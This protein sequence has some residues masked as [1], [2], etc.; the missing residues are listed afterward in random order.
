MYRRLSTANWPFAVKFAFPGLLAF[1]LV[2][3]LELSAT[4]TIN[5]LN[6]NLHDVVDYKFNAS[7]LLAS[8]VSKLRAAN[9]GLYHLQ[10]LQAAGLAPNVNEEAQTITASLDQVIVNLTK[11]KT[12]YAVAADMTKIDAALV[13][14]KNYKDAVGFVASMLDI[15]FKAT[16]NFLTPLDSAYNQ[17]I[18]D[19]SSIATQY[20]EDS[21]RQ[22][23]EAL[24][25]AEQQKINLYL[26]SFGA[27]LFTLLIV[28]WIALT[29]LRS[30]N[31]VAKATQDL[32]E[33]NVD[34][35][36]SALSRRDELNRIVQA[37]VFKGNLVNMRLFKAENITIA[38]MLDTLEQGLFSFGSDGV[39]LPIYSKACLNLIEGSPAGRPIAE[40]L[41]QDFSMRETITLL[42]DVLFCDSENLSSYDDILGLLPKTFV[43][44]QGLAI[45]L[46]YR[47]IRKTSGEL[48][49]ILVAATDHTDKVAAERIGQEREK[50]VL[51]MLR[52]IENRNL[53]VHFYL[54]ASAYCLSLEEMLSGQVTLEQIKRDV[55]TMK[56]NGS[57]FY[58]EGLVG[59]LHDLETELSDVAT[60]EEAGFVLRRVL[61]RM[62]NSLAEV[63]GDVEAVLGEGF[64]RQGVMR[65]VPLERLKR[66]VDKVQQESSTRELTMSV[67]GEP[68]RKQLSSLDMG[69]QELA[70]R[71]GKHVDP[72]VFTGDDFLI[73]SEH[74]K[75]LFSTFAHIASNIISHAAEAPEV[76]ADCGKPLALT[77]VID[78]Q[79]F[80][81]EG[82]EW[83]RISFTDDGAGIDVD[84][85]RLKLKAG[86]EAPS[87]VDALSDQQIAQYI[88]EPSLST[89]TQITELAGRGVGMNA[90]KE[91]ALRLGGTIYVESERHNFTRIVIELPFVWS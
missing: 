29:T 6:A 37:L 22:S 53:F 27:V 57:I 72:C 24:A 65:L 54:T 79:K 14:L 15:N 19:L 26:L 67:L 18:A 17:T 75:E 39:C 11:F 43:H 45:S 42:L 12:D 2:L 55:H 30:V 16:V 56:G 50:K 46:D 87:T 20:L 66:L 28:F 32:S 70:S 84:A 61:P 36:I 35:D 3:F 31:D 83:F 88:F 9:G 49:S 82:T 13:N 8:S 74:Y 60:M 44:S 48:H 21:K 81:R 10:T 80:E 69:L 40:V 52:I 47:P 41:T 64:D 25:E 38:T 23:Q 59:L 34:I 5:S 62:H 85:L 78:T 7:V 89:Q 63:R 51:R 4:T 77:V 33:G 73:L 90:I 76:R 71:Y 58:L 86:H 91:E 1:L 68:I